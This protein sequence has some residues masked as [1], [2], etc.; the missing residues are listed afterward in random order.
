MS[1][2]NKSLLSINSNIDI[3]TTKIINAIKTK[4]TKNDSNNKDI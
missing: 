3:N 2:L 4:I 1:L